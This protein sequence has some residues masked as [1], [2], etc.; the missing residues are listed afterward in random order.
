MAFI[1]LNKISAIPSA[2]ISG[3]EVTLTYT[4]SGNDGVS[5]NIVYSIDPATNLWFQLPDGTTTQKLDPDTP[6]LIT[7]PM[8]VVKKVTIV[9]LPPKPGA[10]DFSHFSIDVDVTDNVTSDSTSFNMTI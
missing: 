5:L 9:K 4:I 1:Q 2:I 8:Q 6:N 3:Q 7:P 10:G